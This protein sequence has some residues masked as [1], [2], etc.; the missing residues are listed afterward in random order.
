MQIMNRSHY[1][2]GS[3]DLDYYRSS[4]GLITQRSHERCVAM[5][6]TS[7]V[8]SSVRTSCPVVRPQTGN[9]PLE[10]EGQEVARGHPR[11]RVGVAVGDPFHGLHL[12]CRSQFPLAIFRRMELSSQQVCRQL[13]YLPASVFHR[14]SSLPCVYPCINSPRL[15]NLQC[16]RCRKRKIRCSGDTGDGQQCN[17]CKQAGLEQGQCLFLRVRRFSSPSLSP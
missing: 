3:D 11:R 17:N 13:S 12:S 1:G 7:P 9:S 2:V 14:L 6:T 16:A 4:R 15:T 8:R 10:D 5:S